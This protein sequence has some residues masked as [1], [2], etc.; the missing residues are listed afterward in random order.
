MRRVKT[1]IPTPFM[2]ISERLHNVQLAFYVVMCSGNEVFRSAWFSS[3]WV[4]LSQVRERLASDVLISSVFVYLPS[5]RLLCEVD[6]F[7][8]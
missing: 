6:G 5:G 8:R 2:E 4:A 1:Y 3:A 7:G